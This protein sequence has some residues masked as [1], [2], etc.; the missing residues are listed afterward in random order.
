MELTLK[1]MEGKPIG[2]LEIPEE[3]LASLSDSLKSEEAQMSAPE[4]EEL[5]ELRKF[6]AGVEEAFS[7]EESF[8]E[9]AT[10]LGFQAVIP[11]ASQAEVEEATE[12]ESELTLEEAVAEALKTEEA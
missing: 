12:P 11:E 5:A 10:N 8:V 1:N 3:N 7:S 6:K 9:L 2:K 4:K